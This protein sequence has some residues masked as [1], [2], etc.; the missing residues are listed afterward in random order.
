MNPSRGEHLTGA[1]RAPRPA[2]P[3]PSPLAPPCP[4]RPLPLGA[5][6]PP[7]PADGSGDAEGAVP[8]VGLEQPRVEPAR[9]VLRG[10]RRS[11]ARRGLEWGRAGLQQ[12]GRRGP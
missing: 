11:P 8:G 9:G 1:S 12:H 2:G 10:S 5:E 6:P 3:C 7:R 4:R